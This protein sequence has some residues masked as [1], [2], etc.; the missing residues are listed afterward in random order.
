MQTPRQSV[1]ETVV[2]VAI[3]L[4]VAFTVNMLVLPAFGFEATAG[5]SIGIA[6]IFTAVSV[7]RGYLVR[8]MFNHLHKPEPELEKEWKPTQF[9]DIPTERFMLTDGPCAGEWIEAHVNG[10]VLHIPVTHHLN[11]ALLGHDVGLIDVSCRAAKYV[12][13]PLC[14]SMDLNGDRVTTSWSE[15]RYDGMSPP[16]I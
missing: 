12:R 6:A 13:V 15:W 2:S 4:V 5:D 14:Y 8:R 11:P 3:G 7:V 9:V 16:P 1:V 10:S